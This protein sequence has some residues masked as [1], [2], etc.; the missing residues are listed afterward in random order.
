MCQFCSEHGEGKL[1]YLNAGNYATEL[2]NDLERRRFIEHFYHR[3]IVKGNREVSLLE[4]GFFKR[5]GI[6]A[7][8]REKIVRN[9]KKNH[10]GQVLPLEDVDR[11][12]AMAQTITRLACGCRW[13]KEKKESRLCY[14]VTLGVP[15]WTELIDTDFFGTPDLARFE[16][17]DHTQA[18]ENI[19]TADREG[20]VHSIWTFGTPFIGAICN[21]APAYCLALRTT[22]GLGLT[23]M[24]RS[25]YVAAVEAGACSGCGAC[26]PQCHFNAIA[27]DEQGLCRIDPEKC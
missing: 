14:G 1:W 19:R 5:L 27:Y 16:T 12:L 21:C 22:V 3:V 13:A 9:S 17:L 23:S 25:E 26:L 6:P 7:A 10:F 8:I 2:L 18:M 4:K 15:A 11:V 20:H 24:F